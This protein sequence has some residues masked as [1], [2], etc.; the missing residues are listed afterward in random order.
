MVIV[1]PKQLLRSA[2]LACVVAAVFG[3]KPFAAWVDGSMVAGTVV[4]QAADGWEGV[5]QRIG[6]DQVYVT[7]RASVRTTEAARF[8]GSD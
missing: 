4:Q 1:S 7:L 6:L 5:M 3:A 2:L 8:E